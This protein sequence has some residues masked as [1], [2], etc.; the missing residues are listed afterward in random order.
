MP[1]MPF[2]AEE[3]QEISLLLVGGMRTNASLKSRILCTVQEH[4]PRWIGERTREPIRVPTIGAVII[5]GCVRF[6]G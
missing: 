3:G 1:R 6:V 5:E 2:L 4:K